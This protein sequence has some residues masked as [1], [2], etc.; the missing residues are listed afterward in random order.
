MIDPNLPVEAL[1]QELRT[2]SPPAFDDSR[3]P[4]IFQYCNSCCLFVFFRVF[5]CVSTHLL[6]MHIY[7]NSSQPTLNSNFKSLIVD[8]ILPEG[9][10]SPHNFRSCQSRAHPKEYQFTG[11]FMKAHLMER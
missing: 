10:N 9:P 8:E 6:T 7:T 5:F 1:L 2:F 11:R 4:L 3:C